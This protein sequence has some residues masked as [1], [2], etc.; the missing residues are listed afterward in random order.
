M[1]DPPKIHSYKTLSK[2]VT[3][4]RHNVK[5]EARFESSGHVTLEG[6]SPL[7]LRVYGGL[8]VDRFRYLCSSFWRIMKHSMIRLKNLDFA[9]WEGGI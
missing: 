8:V 6:S 3:S 7:W 5:C 2:L 1:S 4:V 9:Q